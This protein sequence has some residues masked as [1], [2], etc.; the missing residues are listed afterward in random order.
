MSFREGTAS[1]PLSKVE[2]QNYP[3]LDKVR[4][5]INHKV[6]PRNIHTGPE[7]RGCR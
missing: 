3:Q 2:L 5:S 4:R 7:V 1:F 6:G